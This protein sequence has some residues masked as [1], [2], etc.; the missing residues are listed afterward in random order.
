MKKVKAAILLVLIGVLLFASGCGNQAPPEPSGTTEGSAYYFK[1][2]ERAL[3]R[4]DVAT[5]EV[6]T[7]WEVKGNPGKFSYLVTEEKIFLIDDNTLYSINFDGTGTYAYEG[8]YAAGNCQGLPGLALDGD[9]LYT[10]Y[11]QGGQFGSAD[12]MAR[13]PVSGGKWETID[14]ENPGTAFQVADGVLYVCAQ[15]AITMVNG[16][17]TRTEELP[18]GLVPLCWDGETLYCQDGTA[19]T[20]LPEEGISVTEAFSNEY[21][22]SLGGVGTTA[23]FRQEDGSNAALVICHIDTGETET[24]DF[25]AERVCISGKRAVALTSTPDA[26]G[27]AVYVWNPGQG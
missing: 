5:D 9:W 27:K 3:L 14:I 1:E 20:M 25:P 22:T 2:T 18:A 6:S 16:G 11:S 19:V 23:F 24:V 7:V 21:G 15:N 17:K 12:E 13:I 26:A 10:C 8:K 4:L